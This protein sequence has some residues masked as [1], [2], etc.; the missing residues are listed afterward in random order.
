MIKYYTDNHDVD[1]DKVTVMNQSGIW[2]NGS[3][4]GITYRNI[5]RDVSYSSDTV[6]SLKK[7]HRTLLHLECP[8]RMLSYNFKDR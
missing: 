8:M 2:L 1:E 7:K 4:A 6:A 3:T 5:R